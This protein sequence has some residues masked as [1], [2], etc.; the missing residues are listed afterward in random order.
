[1]KHVQVLLRPDER[2]W[3]QQRKQTRLKRDGPTLN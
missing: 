1:M 2:T 3:F